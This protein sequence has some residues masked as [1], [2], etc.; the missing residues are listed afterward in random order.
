[1][2][3]IVP[4]RGTLLTH[5]QH[6]VRTGDCTLAGAKHRRETGVY[7]SIAAI[8]LDAL[9]VYA[10]FTALYY[11]KIPANNDMSLHIQHL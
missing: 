6:E 10:V 3:S 4:G 7:F 1:M 8:Y 9:S 5:L 11:I 2:P